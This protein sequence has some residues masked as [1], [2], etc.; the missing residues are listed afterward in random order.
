MMLKFIINVGKMTIKSSKCITNYLGQKIFNI[1]SFIGFGMNG[2]VQN[3][4]QPIYF[5]V[6]L[7]QLIY[8]GLLSIPVISLTAIF[9][10]AVLALQSY[11]SMSKLVAE[12]SVPMILVLSLTRELG[13]VLSGL[14]L[15]GRAGA[16]ITAEISTMRVTDQVDAIYTLSVNPIK[17]LIAPRILATM[18]SLPFLVLIFN[19]LGFTG[20]YLIAIH[21]L[22]FLAPLYIN[23]TLKYLKAIDIISGLTKATFFGLIIGINSCYKGYYATKG[24]RGVGIATTNAV[25]SSSVMIL[26]SNYIITQFFI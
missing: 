11:Y 14:I 15:A 10:G 7:S 4:L 20:G 21:K 9:S 16:A 18:L 19:I 12:S 1:L 5:K 17:Y 26:I 2:L 25:V 24:A 8:I 13:P 6:L 23:N 3:F 22:N